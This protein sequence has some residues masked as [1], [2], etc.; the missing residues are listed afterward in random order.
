MRGIQY[1]APLIGI[2]TIAITGSPA[3][4]GDDGMGNAAI[5]I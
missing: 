5:K 2:A 3:C 1:S 4:A